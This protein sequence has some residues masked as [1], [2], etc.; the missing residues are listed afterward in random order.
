MSPISSMMSILSIQKLEGFFDVLV[1]SVFYW[2]WEGRRGCGEGSADDRA[3]ASIAFGA[4]ERGVG[5]IE[6]GGEVFAGDL[7][8]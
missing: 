7:P 8:G 4:K 1:S 5:A 3:I 6:G 2:R